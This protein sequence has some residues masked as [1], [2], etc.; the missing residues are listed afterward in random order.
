[1]T[2]TKS[3][4]TRPHGLLGNG[5]GPVLLLICGGIWIH[6]A[7]T[8]VVAT[9][10]PDAVAE[11]GGLAWV[12]WAWMLELI[13]AIVAAAC[14]GLLA[15]RHGTGKMTA[16]AASVFAVG[17]AVT[18]LAWDMG[19]FLA[20]RLLQGIGGGAMV[21][22][23][24]IGVA[25]LF[26]ERLWTRAYAVVAVVWGTSALIGP[27]VGG[28]FAEIGF[29][30][31]AF[32]A[33]AAQ[34]VLVVIAAPALLRRAAA[35]IDT[36]ESG[37]PAP[38]L[39]FLVPAVLV[40]GIAGVVE[41][42]WISLAAIIASIVLLAACIV[43]DRRSA[44]SLLPRQSL[45]IAHVAAGLTMAFLLP[46][47]A[48]SFSTYGP[49]LMQ[50]LHGLTPLEFGYL[51]ALESIAWSITALLIAHFPIFREETCLRVGGFIV[52]AAIAIFAAAMPNGPLELVVAAALLQGG[53]FGLCWAYVSR[54]VVAAAVTEDRERAAGALPTIQM[55]GYA[56]GAASAGVVANGL[57]F[58]S[59]EGG[60]AAAHATAETVALWVFLAFIPTG[61]GGI[62]AA[63]R[64]ARD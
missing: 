63:W 47:S 64:L 23:C 40:I 13:G 38:T 18:A 5:R 33:F 10:M 59:T 36:A 17:C 26:P 11:L 32:W 27:L 52:V 43:A 61:I 20:G 49:L 29:W 60:G 21:A 54:R 31:G 62:V 14:C 37:V 22:L 56:I 46:L 8:T 41:T 2:D 16:L 9:V 45:G 4:A 57:G 51:A 3:D 30:Q 44:V 50:R 39:T 7:D 24:H 28:L 15:A 48:I 19:G 12:A 35:H 55:L 58:A 53:G 34:A 1:M 6:A 42:W 25:A